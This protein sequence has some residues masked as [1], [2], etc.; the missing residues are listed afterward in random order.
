M[1]KISKLKRIILTISILVIGLSYFLYSI[2]L[3]TSELSINAI[4]ARPTYTDPMSFFWSDGVVINESLLPLSNTSGLPE[5]SLLFTP[6]RILSVKDSTLSITYQPGKDWI[7]DGNK[8]K[9]PSGS[10]IPYLKIQTLIPKPIEGTYFHSKQLAVTYMHRGSWQGPIPKYLGDTIL[11]KTQLKL[12]TKTPLKVILIGDSIAVGAN[13]SGYYKVAP[14]LPIWGKL[15]SFTK[16]QT[17]ESLSPISCGQN[18]IL[19]LSNTTLV[20][21]QNPDL[22]IAFNER[23]YEQSVCFK[24]LKTPRHDRQG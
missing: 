14:L 12:N 2:S 17:T 6:A 3:N 7:L 23:W 22:V 15:F 5:A 9:I 1:S 10:R 11:S 18:F 4:S 19:G 13:V 16:Y 21:S 20:A 8:I 24:A